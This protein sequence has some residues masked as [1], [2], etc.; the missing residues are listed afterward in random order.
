MFL[1][2]PSLIGRSRDFRT[3]P[4][5]LAVIVFTSLGW[6]QMH[7]VHIAIDLFVSPYSA[8]WQNIIDV[9]NYLLASITF[10]IS[11]WQMIIYTG[12]ISSTP[13]W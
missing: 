5:A 1:C 10:I 12:Q 11:F 2:A 6:S 4:Y 9:F 7:K 3:D 13:I 8:F